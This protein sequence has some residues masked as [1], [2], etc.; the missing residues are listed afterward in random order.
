MEVVMMRQ[1]VTV[2]TLALVVSACK[3]TPPQATR[4]GYPSA[5]CGGRPVL[6]RPTPPPPPLEPPPIINVPPPAPTLH[7][8]QP[9][10]TIT[11][12]EPAQVQIEPCK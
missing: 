2:L 10:V 7:P 12:R 3:H 1:L 9:I 11:I 8:P 6:P 5:P 4:S